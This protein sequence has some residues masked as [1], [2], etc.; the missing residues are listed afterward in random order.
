MTHFRWKTVAS[1]TLVLG[2]QTALCQENPDA[3]R[4]TPV[5]Q[6]TAARD[7]MNFRYDFLENVK[8]TRLLTATPETGTWNPH[9]YVT[10]FKG[11]SKSTGYAYP[12]STVVG[13]HSWVIYSVNKEDI[14][15]ARIPLSKL[16]RIR[17]QAREPE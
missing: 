13:D 17:S 3:H 10:Y 9:P 15:M 5:V 4:E 8:T 7:A 6:W 2:A 14:E 16:Y 1:L 11:R 12:H